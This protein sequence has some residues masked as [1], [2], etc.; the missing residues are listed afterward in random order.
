MAIIVQGHFSSGIAALDTGIT[1]IEIVPNGAGLTLFTHSG[2]N[3]GL[4]GWGVSA[5]SATLVDQVVY[6]AGWIGGT[7][8]SIAIDAAPG[9]GS[10][11]LFGSVSNGMLSAYA[12]GQNGAVGSVS[13]YTGMGS[14]LARL[15][16][17][18][19]D[20][21]TVVFA[22]ALGQF[23]VGA[24]AGSGAVT[25]LTVLSDG[26]DSHLAFVTAVATATVGG[27]TI[28]FAG[29][30]GEDGLTSFVMSSGTPVLA[31]AV[32]PEDG[33]GIMDPRAMTVVEVQGQSFLILASA[34]GMNGALTVFHV[35]PDG[36]LTR[37][38]HI[39]DNLNTRF[40]GVTDIASVE[41]DGR[42]Y[43]AAGGA[44]DGVSL[45]VVLPDGQLQFLDAIE[46]TWTNGAPG[47][48]ALA[49]VTAIAGGTVADVLHFFVASED[50]GGVTRLTYDVS[51]QG[52]MQ[53][54]TA[55]NGGSL[56]GGGADDILVSG[57]GS[58]TIS[59]GNGDDILVDGAGLD[60]LT[61][62]FGADVFVMRDD[63]TEDR[64]M[65]FDPTVDTL[66]LSSWP[67]FY[68]PASLTIVPNANGAVV[69]W[70][71]E[72]LVLRSADGNPL[73]AGSV[74]NAVR[75]TP[76]R[77]MDLSGYDFPVWDGTLDEEPDVVFG[78][79]IG[80]TDGDDTVTGGAGSEMI[81]LSTGN[82][83]V[84]AG[85]GDD[86]VDG[87]AGHKTVYLDDGD[88]TFDDKDASTAQD[89]DVVRGGA[90]DDTLLMGLG[91]D[92]VDGGTGRDLIRS[93]GGNDRVTGGAGSDEA[94]LG[95]G[96]D[97][98]LDG[99]DEGADHNDI[100]YGEEGDDEITTGNGDDQIDG[101]EGDDRLGGRAGN[102]IIFGGSGVDFIWGATG[103]DQLRGDDGD[104]EIFGGSGQDHM[105]GGAGND[106]MEGGADDDTAHGG[107]GDDTVRGQDG[108]DHLI[109]DEGN[110]LIYG[111]DGRD[112]LVGGDGSDMVY[113][114]SGNDELYGEGGF[115]RMFGED[116]NDTMYGGELR[117][118]LW[119][120]NGDDV[121]YGGAWHDIPKGQ[122]TNDRIYGGNG[123][124]T[125]WG[126]WGNDTLRGEWGEDRIY[127]ESGNDVIDG[128]G[129][130]DWID[131]GTGND[132]LYGGH[133]KDVIFAGV[134]A[135][136]LY[137]GY[138]ND[139]MFGHGHNDVMF[140]G[141]GIDRMRGGWGNDVIHGEWGADKLWGELGNDRIYGGGL[142]D[143]II[144]G[145]G[146]DVL[147]GGSGADRFEFGRWDD[148]DKIMD[149]SMADKI[150]LH[151]VARS[152]V[153]V[154]VSGNSTI[155]EWGSESVQL[156]NFTH[157]GFDK[158]DII[159]D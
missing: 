130:N 127:G 13:S 50:V 45:F 125:I 18:E 21:D 64:I 41:H 87:G 146:N 131:G 6:N 49:D 134:G 145:A 157:G 154:H 28:V 153:D 109:G 31:D 143:T 141:V 97:V 91:D 54:R 137:G 106:L 14:E 75:E 103:D 136:R 98:Y 78:Y 10:Q 67:F 58:D 128:G 147:Y 61:G 118:V 51:D 108:D 76:D 43:L 30:A 122:G 39:T 57:A 159:F 25:N 124:D 59:A 1:D 140:G 82:D 126:G 105:L 60:I 66:D 23:G 71:D 11:A 133:G 83:E 135:D 19:T 116:G 90:G 15:T 117:D 148:R 73:S 20:G 142:N 102:D 74:R 88:D 92:D 46:N 84:H 152:L 26:E 80:D 86:R 95:A 114:G 34:Q 119:G 79:D 139:V 42:T 32:G 7:G 151:G 100:V 22:D 40:G 158:G 47:Q 81:A 150:V 121:L 72:V 65:D 17:I 107:D 93:G 85:G 62:G 99:D 55:T 111:D 48:A 3:G 33:V 110:D 2:R 24:R 38:D 94:W 96:N 36:S 149:F 8:E 4:A 9:G 35:Q 56:V 29:D 16:D 115:D 27:Q 155:I 123:I 77:A 156:V 53:H 12:V 120:G 70:R 101:G 52:V 89:G 68:D 63:G 104:D 112:R 132:R 5:S 44:D 113:G 144:G 138:G 37:A 129:M 69:T